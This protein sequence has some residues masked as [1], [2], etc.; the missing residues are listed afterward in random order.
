[1][2]ICK[3]IYIYTYIYIYKE[4]RESVCVSDRMGDGVRCVSSRAIKSTRAGALRANDSFI[5]G[6]IKGAFSYQL[7]TPYQ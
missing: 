2:Y 7:V 4:K 1:M 5:N 6:D 3:F